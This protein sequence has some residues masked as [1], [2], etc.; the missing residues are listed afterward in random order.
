MMICVC[1]L[2]EVAD[3]P[4][5]RVHDRADGLVLDVQQSPAGGDLDAVPEAFFRLGLL[6]GDVDQV[7]LVDGGAFVWGLAGLGCQA[8]LTTPV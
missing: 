7:A 5:P 6:P 8:C 1:C 3:D 2:R 4:G